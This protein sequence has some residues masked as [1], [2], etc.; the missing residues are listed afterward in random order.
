MTGLAAMAFFKQKWAKWTWKAEA[1][2]GQNLHHLTMLG[3]YA[4]R[5]V[6]DEVRLDWAYTPTDTLSFWTEIMTNGAPLA[7]RASSPGTPR[8]WARPTRSPART[9]PAASTSTSST[10]SRRASSTTS[11]RCASPA[12][13]S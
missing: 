11:A 3:G 12:R 2:W 9:T 1:V 13:S 4:V 10:G 7:D 6:V 5:D 8:T